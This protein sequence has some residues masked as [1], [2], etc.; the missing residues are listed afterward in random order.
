MEETY[1]DLEQTESIED[2]DLGHQAQQRAREVENEI[3]EG[4]IAENEDDVLSQVG[5]LG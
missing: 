2:V 3:P 4:E 5:Q 1:D